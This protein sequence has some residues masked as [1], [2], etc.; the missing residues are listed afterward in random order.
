[1][2][3]RRVNAF[4]VFNAFLF[5]ATFSDGLTTEIEVNPEFGTAAAAQ[6]EAEKYGSAIGQLP[7]AL[8]T[9]V[10]SVWIHRGVELFG[11]GNNSILIHTGQA[12]LYTAD[13]FL[14]EALVHEG[15]HTSVDPTNAATPGWLAAQA[16]DADFI[17]TYAMDF[18][19]RDDV[20]ESFLPYLALRY[21]QDRIP[22]SLAAAIAMTIPNR[23]AYFDAQSFDVSPIT[24]GPAAV[25][26]PGT[27]TLV[28]GGSAVGVVWGMRRRNWGHQSP[29]TGRH[30][31]RTTRVPTS[32]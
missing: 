1:M 23:I 15:T 22:A 17:S 32:G 9:N 24:A 25:P 29:R 13:G 20:A 7:R 12:D 14:E 28:L 6:V 31:A 10:Q 4:V 18:P 2:F 5:N 21:R 8:R 30:L 26:E 19:D 16:A 11:G 27:L 3:D